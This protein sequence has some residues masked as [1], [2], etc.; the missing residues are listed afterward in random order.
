MSEQQK[1]T[2]NKIIMFGVIGFLAG[3]PLS[4]FF[5]PPIIRKLSLSEYVSNIPGMLTAK[6]S[7]GDA[8]LVGGDPVAVFWM[9]CVITAAIFAL[10]R[11]FILRSKGSENK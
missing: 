11:Y 1:D 8:A 10:A 9:T 6:T 5:Q 3:I 4:Y 2:S 7:P